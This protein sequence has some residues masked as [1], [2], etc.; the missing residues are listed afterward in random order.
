MERFRVCFAKS[1]MLKYISHL[2]L[3]RTFLRALRRA[4]IPLAYSQ[5][6]SPQPRVVFAAPLGIGIE[7]INEYLDLFLI[8]RLQ[9]GLLEKRINRQ[10]PTGLIVK[11]I[12]TIGL[13]EP[14][15]SALVGAALYRARFEMDPGP[16]QEKTYNL[17]SA[18]QLPKERQNKKGKK[19]VDI[20]PFILDFW[21]EE[22]DGSKNL[23]MLLV[24]GNRGGARPEEIL[25]LLQLPELSNGTTLSREF[26][27]F[28]VK[29][30][31]LTPGGAIYNNINEVKAWKG[32]LL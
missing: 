23:S 16:L 3:Q 28:R 17:L 32:K 8:R 27:F 10:L 31:L 30:K 20:R 9:M 14:A 15:I 21:E 2:D 5:G 22:R 24:T 6:F 1:G 7:G 18:E 13:E 19:Q 4:K 26:L 25:E 11:D 12:C 29:E